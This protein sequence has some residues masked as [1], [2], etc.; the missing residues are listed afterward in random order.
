MNSETG[1]I[2]LPW[3]S[4]RDAWF[5]EHSAKLVIVEYK[6]LVERPADTL[7]F[8][9]EQL[10]LPT[11]AHDFDNVVYEADAYD[12]DLGMPGMHTVKAR[13]EPLR[14]QSIIP[15]DLF[16]KYADTSFWRRRELQR[17]ASVIG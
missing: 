7:A 6:T 9:Y 2:G 10:R 8:I 13:V 12:V 16:A 4:F 14:R 3:S 1:L 15:P 11:F 5:S 17:G